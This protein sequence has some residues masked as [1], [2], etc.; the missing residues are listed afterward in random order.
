MMNRAHFAALLLATTLGCG[1]PPT[2]VTFQVTLR[3]STTTVSGD[4]VLASVSLD[5]AGVDSIRL[6]VDGKDIGAAETT[7]AAIEALA[8]SKVIDVTGMPD[9]THSMVATAA[10]KDGQSYQSASVSFLVARERSS[11]IG[12]SPQDGSTLE[13]R[14]PIDLS[15]TKPMRCDAPCVESS[16]FTVSGLGSAP[17]VFRDGGLTAR[18]EPSERS[19]FS[20]ST[21]EVTASMLTDR[22]HNRPDGGGTCGYSLKRFEPLAPSPP[23]KELSDEI[24]VTPDGGIAF[25]TADVDHKYFMVV[26]SGGAWRSV[27]VTTF[28]SSIAVEE[29]GVLLTSDYGTGRVWRHGSSGTLGIYTPDASVPAGRSFSY[30]FVRAGAGGHLALFR[31]ETDST[32]PYGNVRLRVSYFDGAA[33]STLPAPPSSD[34]IQLGIGRDGLPYCA[35][36]MGLARWSGS[37]WVSTAVP[38][39]LVMSI[40]VEAKAPMAIMYDPRID[41]GY[42]EANF[43]MR[44]DPSGWQTVA[45]LPDQFVLFPIPL[46]VDSAGQ[47]YTLETSYKFLSDGG[48]DKTQSLRTV[49]DG[50]EARAW[51]STVMPDRLDEASLKMVGDRP[52]L[53]FSDD[54]AL[55]A[56][57]VRLY[58]WR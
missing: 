20:E 40:F 10:A 25:L 15:Y 26:Y 43:L 22:N 49:V 46:A 48:Y 19:D 14:Q 5:R 34:C 38:P 30:S 3:L 31:E 6:S 2:T 1:A 41:G 50:G 21:L 36:R 57:P 44:A 23:I 11:F 9:G 16:A 58:E 35:S 51:G 33:W 27:R 47:P 13:W 17:L 42:E 56:K 52:I 37:A 8:F 12:C 54:Y 29:N 39:P 53:I 18:F 32:T 4:S 55:T 45:R 7:G 24:L 28:P